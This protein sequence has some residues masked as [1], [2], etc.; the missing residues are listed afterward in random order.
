RV[1]E[2]T[3][4]SASCRFWHIVRN[5]MLTLLLNIFTRSSRRRG[6]PARLLISARRG[7]FA[8]MFRLWASEVKSDR[9]VF[10]AGRF[11]D[12]V[13]GQFFWEQP[14]SLVRQSPLSGQ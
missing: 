4:P 9:P 2:A 14:G 12:L 8:E 3:E 11:L 13:L 1:E 6:A 7:T 5:R 10:P